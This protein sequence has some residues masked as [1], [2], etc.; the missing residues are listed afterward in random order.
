VG[1]FLAEGFKKPLNEVLEFKG[2]IKKFDES[3]A[4]K[5]NYKKDE[6]ESSQLR[7]TKRQNNKKDTFFGGILSLKDGVTNDI[8][9][10]IFDLYNYYE[11]NRDK[12]SNTFPNLIRMALRLLI[13][14][15]KFSQTENI[16][17]Y[18]K[19]NFSNAKEKLSQDQRTTLNTNGVSENS[20]ASL[21]HVGAHNYSASSNLEQTIAMSMIIGEML[22]TTHKK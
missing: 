12:L 2:K 10:D 4:K 17:D 18:I 9:R 11:K 13:D 14:S 20:L 22:K 21:L 5:V 6:E 15:A 19:L 3:F 1:G 8:Y 16:E 7:K